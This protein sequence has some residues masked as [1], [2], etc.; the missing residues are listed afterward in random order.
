MRHVLLV[1]LQTWERVVS[2]GPQLVVAEDTTV[3][4]AGA[5]KLFRPGGAD[6]EVQPAIAAGS[7]VAD[8]TSAAASSTDSGVGA[9]PSKQGV[10]SAARERFLARK[11]AKKG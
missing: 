9:T 4:G 10:T 1:P 11:K 7:A 5:T 8:C 3:A 2:A 6:S